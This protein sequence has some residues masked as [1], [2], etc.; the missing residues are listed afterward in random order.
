MA[1]ITFNFMASSHVTRKW[2][3][4]SKL[5][6]I[7]NNDKYLEACTQFEPFNYTCDLM[8]PTF[9][10]KDA[11]LY[12]LR[13]DLTYYPNFIANA[14]DETPFA[15]LNG[16][17]IFPR[18]PELTI[19]KPR[20]CA[21]NFTCEINR[22]IPFVCNAYAH[23]IDSILL[24]QIPCDSLDDCYTKRLNQE[25]IDSKIYDDMDKLKNLKEKNSF[26]LNV[27][28]TQPFILACHSY[29][30]MGKNMNFYLKV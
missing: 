19:V 4:N 20:L 26:T 13:L 11:G 22:Q 14:I 17:M 27:N 21:S 10:E 29:N 30:D 8:M 16:T 6:T 3:H 18:V 25:L 1:T 5:L 24:T 7:D 15:I 23:K 9:E 28:V 2:Y 12:S